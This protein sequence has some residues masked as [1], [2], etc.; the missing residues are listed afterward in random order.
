MR[1][2]D[3]KR[4]EIRVNGT[5][6]EIAQTILLWRGT[7]QQQERGRVKIRQPSNHGHYLF[8]LYP[9]EGNHERIEAMIIAA[10]NDGTRIVGEGA[11]KDWAALGDLWD[12]L[13]AELEPW[14]M[15]AEESA[16][17]SGPR[18]WESMLTRD[19]QSEHGWQRKEIKELIVDIQ[20]RISPHIT[21]DEIADLKNRID[22]YC[23]HWKGQG[24]GRPDM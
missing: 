13:R 23:T 17:N 8:Y 5:P 6:D 12:E 24:Y 18:T 10:P 9:F 2:S 7:I 3:V 14:A 11:A 15:D 20:R 16:P 19:L 1:E 21:A 22:S 4:A